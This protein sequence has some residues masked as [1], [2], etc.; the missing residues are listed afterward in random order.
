[1]L[2]KEQKFARRLQAGDTG[3]LHGEV[4]VI[5]GPLGM[6]PWCWEGQS[7]TKPWTGRPAATVSAFSL[8]SCASV[9]VGLLAEQRKG[10][11]RLCYVKGWG[12][13]YMCMCVYFLVCFSD[14]ILDLKDR[15]KSTR[16]VGI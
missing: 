4:R 7:D 10:Q 1:M 3:T 16:T 14:D 5:T 9:A 6:C 8:S 15:Y 11:V 12:V 2:G 13:V